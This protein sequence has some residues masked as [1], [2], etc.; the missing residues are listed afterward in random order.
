MEFIRKTIEKLDG[1]G[2]CFVFD[3]VR[4]HHNK[5]ML[6]MITDS[7]NEYLFT[8]PYSPNNNPIET[9]F[10]VLKNKYRKICLK[11][12]EEGENTNIKNSIMITLDDFK[13]EYS[14]EMILKLFI[15]SFTYNY[16][17]LEKELRDRMI[18]RDS[19]KQ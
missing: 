14:N 9:I 7:N 5:Q 17:D 2:H 6:K 16:G 18:I 3:N 1:T 12:T 19:N 4:F 13:H 10:G 11:N 15:H 8:P